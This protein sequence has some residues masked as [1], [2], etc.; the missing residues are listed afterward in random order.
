LVAV[1]GAAFGYPLVLGALAFI[2]LTGA[3]QAVVT[4]LW[5]GEIWETVARAGRRALARLLPRA[6]VAAEP[7][8]RHI[9]YGVAIA[10]GSVWTVWWQGATGG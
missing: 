4:L 9:P 8:G 2:T 7:L 10:L 3:V 6:P 5:L 1:V